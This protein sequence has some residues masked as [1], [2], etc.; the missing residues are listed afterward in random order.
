[1]DCYFAPLNEELFSSIMKILLIEDDAR[2]SAF[3]KKGL[4]E[5]GY[6]VDAAYDGLFG[7]KLALE[8][9]YDLIILDII[10]P[11]R[12]GIE[13]CR[14]IREVN[15]QVPILMLTALDALD[16]KVRGL[17]S[18]ADDYVV[19]PFNFSELLARVRALTRPRSGQPG[20]STYRIADLEID[21]EAKSVKRGQ[22]VIRLTAREFALLEVFV[23]N[24]G[25]VLTRAELTER[26][27]DLSFDTGTNVVDVYV[28]YLRKKIDKDYPTKLIH[29]IIGVGY[30][31]RE[32]Q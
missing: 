31:L 8:A 32:E 23:R 26:V 16:D 11:S 6:T 10:L 13:V 15:T 29:T 25:K 24:A 7:S 19:K 4:E 27:W 5:Q 28:N 17:D 2:V 14:A 1:M 9:L 30:V 20:G 12:S 21:T 22:R 3:I 18:G